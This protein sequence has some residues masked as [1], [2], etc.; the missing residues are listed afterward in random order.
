MTRQSSEEKARLREAV[1]DRVKFLLEYHWLGNQRQMARDLEVSQGL[2][3]KI[4]NGL[5]GAGRR[6]LGI[7]GS[8]PGVNADWVL[9]GEGQP[10]NL[11]PKGTLPV[12]LGVLPGSPAEWPQ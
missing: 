12:A 4:I 9:R 10:L 7:L 2:I 8:Q 11:P 1:R 5:Q 6:F 3:S